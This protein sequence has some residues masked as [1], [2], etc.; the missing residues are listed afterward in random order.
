LTKLDESRA[1]T[2]NSYRKA[3][4]HW[5][6]LI[7]TPHFAIFLVRFFLPQKVVYIPQNLKVEC[8]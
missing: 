6:V 1:K 8:L 3:V 7:V 5:Q 2:L 4:I